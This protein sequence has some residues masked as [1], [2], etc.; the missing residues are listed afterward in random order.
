LQLA[1][2]TRVYRLG[3]ETVHALDGVNLTVSRGE[4]LAVGEL[5]R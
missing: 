3:G 2:V 1:D 4:F 5:G